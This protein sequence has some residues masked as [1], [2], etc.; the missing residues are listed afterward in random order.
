[1]AQ[2]VGISFARTD[3]RKMWYCFILL[4]QLF[5]WLEL[6]LHSDGDLHTCFTVMDAVL[7]YG[8]HSQWFWVWMDILL[9]IEILV[10]TYL[11]FP[12]KELMV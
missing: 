12:W 9:F 2:N 10:S 11:F 6:L 1:M 3:K 7:P 5:I 4:M 8:L